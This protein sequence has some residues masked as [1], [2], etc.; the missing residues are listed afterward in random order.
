MAEMVDTQKMR[1]PGFGTLQHFKV[2]PLYAM[3]RFGQWEE[4]LSQPEPAEDLVY[5]R[6]VWHYA[7]G[8]AYLGLGEPNEA[9]QELEQLKALATDPALKKVTLWDINQT[10]DL[11]AI[12]QHVLA[13]ETAFQQG[14]VED[15]IA[16]LQQAVAVEDKLNYDEPPA[17]Y[18][19]GAAISGGDAYRYR[20]YGGSGSNIP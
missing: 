17:W 12:A 13:G 15:A 6:G 14:Q 7:R 3:I 4:I 8:W 2:M 16:H 5:P 1:A 19:S 20:S 11:L 9:A 18:L 10:T